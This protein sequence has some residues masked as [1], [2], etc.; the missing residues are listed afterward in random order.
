MKFIVFKVVFCGFFGAGVIHKCPTNDYWFWSNELS[1]MFK[2]TIAG[3]DK[4]SW[5]SKYVPLKLVMADFT[6]VLTEQWIRLLQSS[7]VIIKSSSQLLYWKV[8]SNIK[9]YIW[10]WKY[11]SQSSPKEDIDSC[12]FNYVCEQRKCAL[13]LPNHHDQDSHA[14]WQFEFQKGVGGRMSQ[15]ANKKDKT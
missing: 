2:R 7:L 3:P 6:C 4:I 1:L 12:H 8:Q 15:G 11:V 5:E 9:K 13:N 14:V 10:L